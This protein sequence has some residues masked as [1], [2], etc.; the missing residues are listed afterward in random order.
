[1]DA[2]DGLPMPR[3]IWAVAAILLAITMAVLD[4]AIANVALPTIARD[5]HADAASAIWVVNAYQLA[6]VV[7]LLP[8]ASL[9][10]IVGYRRVFRGGVIVFTL[11]S[12]ACAL[13][14]TLV[15]LT[16][17][18]I[19]QGFGAAA[20]M[21]LT[22][23]LIR[24]SYPQ[25]MLGRAIG[26][27][28]LIISIAA[29]TGPS[30]AAAILAVANW[31]W[32]FAVNLPIGVLAVIASVGLPRTDG[33]GRKFDWLS[34]LINALAFG[35][36]IVGVDAVAHVG[37][38]GVLSIVGAA[39]AAFALV[40]REWRRPAPMAPID[41]LKIRPIAFAVGA[42][43]CS[44]TA[45]MLAYVT[46]PFFFE[47]AFHKDQVQTGI[48]ITPWPVAVGIT[49]S[50]SGRL[51]DKLPAALLCGLGGAIFATGILQLA[52][53]PSDPETWRIIVAM[54]TAG[55][56]FGLYQAPNNRE[57]IGWSPRARS[58]AA[59]GLLA[60]ARLLGQT[61]GAAFVA[62]VFRLDIHGFR[63]ALFMAVGF[64]VA[65]A[66]VSAL[67]PRGRFG[68][69]M[70]AAVIPPPEAQPQPAAPRPAGSKA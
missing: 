12:G 61:L 50:I 46:V 53:L 2:E 32:L 41:L 26:I 20:I 8:F 18:R 66:I 17:A 68:E 43:V 49:A 23:A 3:R 14:H 57:I 19:V 6:I 39:V 38:I 55:V 65:S 24:H 51:A 21:S 48:L 1:M 47:E 70:P 11:A 30:I 44:F 4:G 7:S 60:T 40:V 5:V 67:R 9:G 56:G 69:S 13:S 34:A 33:S 63:I 58:G 29:A 15:E 52:L 37:A 45:Q 28:A 10:E 62:L 59:G 42:S 16:A 22:T 36:L 64:A 27:N 31:P 54:L 25:R 35:L